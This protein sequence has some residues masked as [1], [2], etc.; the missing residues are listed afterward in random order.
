MKAKAKS[1]IILLVTFALGVLL[2]VVISNTFVRSHFRGKIDRLRTPEGFIG[3]YERII[4][5]EEAQGDT[6]QVILRNHFEKMKI[7]G[8]E[9]FQKFRA[10]EDSLYQALGPILTQE[11][12]Q[13][14]QEHREW[15]QKRF[16]KSDKRKHPQPEQE[17]ESD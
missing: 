11:Q 9:G 5:P 4:V 16:E 15:M 13:R 2:G 8:E 3:M 17:E 14:L 10:L 1:F 7:Q 12:N 6:L